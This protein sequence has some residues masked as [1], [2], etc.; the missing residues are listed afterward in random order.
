MTRRVI[1]Y[2][3]PS[4]STI[5]KDARGSYQIIFIGNMVS[6][7]VIKLVVKSLVTV[8]NNL[9]NVE[10]TQRKKRLSKVVSAI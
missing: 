8:V 3:F 5:Q 2:L 7:Y 6:G 9:K 1:T 10:L 4:I